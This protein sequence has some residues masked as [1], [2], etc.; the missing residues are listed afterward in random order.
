MCTHLVRNGNLPNDTVMVEYESECETNTQLKSNS[1]LSRSGRISHHQNQ[2]IDNSNQIASISPPEPI[3]G[4]VVN[5]FHPQLSAWQ[6]NQTDMHLKGHAELED[7]ICDVVES[8]RNKENASM[9]Q[10]Q[11]NRAMR[12]YDSEVPSQRFSSD[13]TVEELFS[14]VFEK[15]E[16]PQVIATPGGRFGACKLVIQ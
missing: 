6:K 15:S 10:V 3:I 2:G 13:T 9:L 7:K 5:G 12:S 11:K 16:V 8:C 1:N 14:D 4:V